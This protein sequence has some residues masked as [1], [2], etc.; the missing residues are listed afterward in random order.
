M[1]RAMLLFLC[2]LGVTGVVGQQRVIYITKYLT[3]RDA[4]T[5][6]RL[7]HLDLVTIT[8]AAENNQIDQDTWLGMYRDDSYSD[9]KW[10]RGDEPHTFA[11]EWNSDDPDVGEDCVYKRSTD[12]GAWKSSTCGSVRMFFCL[13]DSLFVVKQ[14]KTWEEALV[15]CR[16]LRSGTRRYDLAS[17]LTPQDHDLLKS[18]SLEQVWTGLRFLGDRWVWV[19]GEDVQYNDITPCPEEKRCGV[20][21]KTTSKLYNI[22]DCKETNYFFCYRKSF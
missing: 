16:S 15:H 3:W 5:Y 21:D 19:G 10:S 1:S 11:N 22:I 8:T 14:M 12:G 7:Y 20:V 9:W 4:Q 2:L 6:C 13:D 17:L 18:Q